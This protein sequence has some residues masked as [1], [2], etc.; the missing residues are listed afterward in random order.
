MTTPVPFGLSRV[1]LPVLAQVLEAIEQG[2]ID[3]PATEADLLAGGFG[4][5][6]RPVADALTGCNR[7]AA[8]A[9]I[10]LV[11]AERVHRPPPRLRLVWTGPESWA[12]ISRDTSMVV[13]E[14][15][16]FARRSVIV[17]GYVFDKPEILEPLHTAM[18]ERGVTAQLFVDIPG[19]APSMHTAD[20]FATTVIDQFFREV[21]TFGLPKPDVYYDPRTAMPGPPWASLH[22]KCIVVDDERTLI[23]SANFTDR[24]QRRNIEAGVL[25]EDAPFAAEVS[26]Q[27]R[28]LITADLVRRYRT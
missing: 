16:A 22:A 1:P 3:C 5:L 20:A 25:I 26:A 6:S 21:W 24:G 2:R 11:I 14:L 4:A 28:L 7:S 27:W 19:S 23:T 10:R 15:F 13:R 9:A 17:G 18:V 12:S 8:C